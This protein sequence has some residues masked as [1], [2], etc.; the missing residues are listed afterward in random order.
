MNQAI[1][2]MPDNDI[3][4]LMTQFMHEVKR[5]DGKDYPASSLNNI[6]AAIQRH[7]KESGCPE[8]N[9][10]DKNKAAIELL[11]KSLDAMMKARASYGVGIV[12]KQA[13]PITPEMENILWDKVIFSL[14]TSRGL[15]NVVFW[16]SCKIV[17]LH[18]ADEH[19]RL[20]VFQFIF[21]HYE[22]GHFLRFVGKRCKNRLGGLKEE[23]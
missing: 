16:Y 8:V 19:K 17:G 6:V 5:R 15:L 4:T 9:F 3:N 14:E 13:Q 22:T 23:S 7:L 2:S 18:A 1:E 12:M 10:Y 11:H 20:E 21:G